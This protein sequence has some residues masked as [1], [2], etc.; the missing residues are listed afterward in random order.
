M[1]WKGLKDHIEVG[2]IH[3]T[4]FPEARDNENI[5]LETFDLISHDLFF[6][7]VEVPTIKDPEIREELKKRLHISRIKTTYA[8]APRIFEMNLDINSIDRTTR[9]H[10]VQ[11]LKACFE[12]ALD[13]GSDRITMISGPMNQV[14]QEEAKDA[15]TESVIELSEFAHKIGLPLHLEIHDY[16]VDKK[17]QMGPTK[18]AIE[19]LHR[20][21]DSYPSFSFLI[22]LSHFPLLGESMEEAVLPLKGKIGYVHIGSCVVKKDDPRYGD[23]HPYFGYPT[24]ENDTDE[25]AEFFKVLAQV[26]YLKP[27]IKV[28]ITLETTKWVG[29]RAEDLI[30]N[31]KR[32][33]LR[34]WEIFVDNQ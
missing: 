13:F 31:A 32:T 22:D 1:Q 10:A 8:T 14:Q 5:L 33:L 12:D 29:E 2:I 7:R 30:I 20:L 24:G 21:Q 19:L 9:M 27:D 28:P 11:E 18:N 17:R 25:I 6:D 34:A 26:G 16:N 15:L 4:L 3:A 23:K